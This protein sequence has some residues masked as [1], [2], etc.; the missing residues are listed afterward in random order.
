MNAWK[1]EIETLGECFHGKSESYN[2]RRVEV[3]GENN[4]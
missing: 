4:R 3:I 2:L 1:R